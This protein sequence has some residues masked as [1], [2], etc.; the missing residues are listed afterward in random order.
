M[1]SISIAIVISL[2]AIVT[3]NAA[4]VEQHKSGANAKQ[5]GN[6]QKHSATVVH[7]HNSGKPTGHTSKPTGQQSKVEK[8]KV[9]LQLFAAENAVNP[10]DVTKY[11]RLAHQKA[12]LEE[13]LAESHAETQRRRAVA[14]KIRESAGRE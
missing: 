6:G 10:D 4:G 2:L 7:A 1:T 5:N 11:I 9:G 3:I 12:E 14:A 8:P 13:E